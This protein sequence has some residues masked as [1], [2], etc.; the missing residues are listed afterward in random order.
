MYDKQ[1]VF[2]FK[3]HGVRSDRT[4]LE[5]IY[6]VILRAIQ[7]FVKNRIV[8]KNSQMLVDFP[9]IYIFYANRMRMTAAK[10][11]ILDHRFIRKE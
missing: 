8:L 3:E 7:K 9:S 2:Q 11:C 6:A 1:V 10:M 4:K 5:Q